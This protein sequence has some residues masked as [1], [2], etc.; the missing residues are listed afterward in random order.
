MFNHLQ[1][2]ELYH[3]NRLH[4]D[5]VDAE[6]LHQLI[7]FLSNH[8]ATASKSL[9]PLLEHGEITF[10]LLWALF[11]PNALLYTTCTGTKKPRC[12][13]FESGEEREFRGEK[14]FQLECRYL[15][16]NGKTF[17]E[18]SESF[19]IDEFRGVKK[20]N[21]LNVFPLDYHPQQSELESWLKDQGATFISLKG[22]QHRQYEGDA[23]LIRKG[24]PDVVKVSGRIMVDAG[25][26]KDVNPTYPKLRM[27]ESLNGAAL[28][29]GW[30]FPVESVSKSGNVSENLIM[31]DLRMED[32][33]DE[34]LMTC[35]ATV[36]GYSLEKKAWRE[37]PKIIVSVVKS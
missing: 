26:F 11:K 14:D 15:D 34:D 22:V 31:T 13:R 1:E 12:V 35:S 4:S 32:V 3:E 37:F 20:I 16:Y 10:D 33:T 36:M 17:G 2:L 28:D 19:T 27:T 30:V 8:F 6:H 9:R 5:S 29:L 21:S 7:R 18:A 25:S 24:Q 23:F